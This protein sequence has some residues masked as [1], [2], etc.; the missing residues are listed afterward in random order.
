MTS[1]VTVGSA[2]PAVTVVEA[3]VHGHGTSSGP[4]Y[5]CSVAGE[6]PS[7][8][9][10]DAQVHVDL[11]VDMDPSLSGEMNSAYAEL[12]AVLMKRFCG[13]VPASGL[14]WLIG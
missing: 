1:F 5:T 12:I 3:H 11:L 13:P 8:V 2:I 7:P 9:T 6:F 10:A 14:S 4:V